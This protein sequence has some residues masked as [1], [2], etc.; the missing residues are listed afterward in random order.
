MAHGGLTG[1]FDF[2]EE[3]GAA[4][5]IHATIAGETVI[6]HVSGATRLNGGEPVSFVIDPAQVQ[7]F[8]ASTGRRLAGEKGSVATSATGMRAVAPA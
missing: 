7:L 2:A 1:R 4:Q 8:D 5:L 6:A 3:L